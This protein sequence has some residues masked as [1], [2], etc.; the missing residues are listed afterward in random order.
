MSMSTGWVKSSHA[1]RADHEMR[2][3]YLG[4]ERVVVVQRVTTKRRTAPA[5]VECY[6]DNSLSLAVPAGG[7]GGCLPPRQGRPTKRERRSI[8]KLLGRPR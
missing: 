4:R 3:G 1:V 7:P 2:L 8:D 6:I 5:A